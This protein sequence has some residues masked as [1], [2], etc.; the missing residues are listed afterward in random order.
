MQLLGMK[1]AGKTT[2]LR[3]MARRLQD[4]GYTAAYEYIPEG[5]RVFNTNT[6]AVE[7]FV[8]DEA[9]RLSLWQKRR[10]WKSGRETRLLISS[11]QD[12]GRWLKRPLTLNVEQLHT[13]DH[14]Q[15]MI[16]RRLT[17][18]ALPEVERVT[19]SEAAVRSVY[20]RFAP[21]FRTAEFFLY[22]LWERLEGV[23]EINVKRVEAMQKLEGERKN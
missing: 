10:L 14:W 18:F 1:G 9:Q 15:T 3:L 13:F 8:L 19:F 20:E 2:A 23:V 21:D 16:E 6:A 22:D 17:Y 5:Q 7:V 11:H 12:V 4:K